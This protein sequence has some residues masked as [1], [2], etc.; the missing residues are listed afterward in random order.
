MKLLTTLSFIILNV[1]FLFPYGWE[2]VYPEITGKVKEIKYLSYENPFSAVFALDEE[3]IGYYKDSLLQK[4]KYDSLPVVSVEFADSL[5]GDILCAM[6]NGT[7]NDGLY[8]FSKES[9]T[10]SLVLSSNSPNF[11]KR[12]YNGIYFF[13]SNDGLFYS[14][15]I[16]SWQ[17]LDSLS[18]KN[19]INVSYAWYEMLLATDGNKLYIFNNDTLTSIIDPD[20]QITDLRGAYVSLKGGSYTDG[21]Y[22]LGVTN[23][24]GLY[25]RVLNPDMMGDFR[26]VGFL[27]I[28]QN[29]NKIYYIQTDHAPSL[30]EIPACSFDY[31]TIY[32][33]ET[34]PDTDFTTDNFII[35]TDTG[36][37]KCEP[38]VG[39][40]NDGNELRD[41]ELQQNYPN[42]FNNET[43]ITL[44]LE[45]SSHIELSIFNSKGEIV[46]NLITSKLNKGNHNFTFKADKLNSGVYF[47]KL[48]ID[49][50][51]KGTKKMLYLK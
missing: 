22:G 12:L 44:I 2:R 23:E 41:F 19:I 32:C 42:P 10:F 26:G 16:S 3:G 51:T 34:Y 29:E 14:E 5:G 31:N 7:K 6:G 15:D 28:C 1:S 20:L 13:G 48:N 33:S 4:F 38:E 9:E 39:I 27:V 35:G 25:C 11:I 50:V 37:Y 17:C 8:K 46:Q 24:L 40:D 49:G 36:V 45:K 21:I 47:Y 30:T 43:S 18:E